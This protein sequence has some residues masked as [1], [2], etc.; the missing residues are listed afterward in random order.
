MPGEI[1]P[2]RR[3]PENDNEYF[4]ILTKAVFQA[5]FSY[6]VIH[7]KWDG[8]REVFED[9]DPEI[10]SRWGDAEIMDA[11]DSEKIVRNVKKIR[12][13]IENASKFLQI[14]KEY[15]SFGQYLDELRP[16]GYDTMKNSI[17]KQFKWLGKT[18]AY[19]LLYSTGEDVPAWDKR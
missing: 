15:G 12:A 8:F 6:K 3:K 5:G 13:T 2:P 4:E 7:N 18:G 1:I 17:T 9:F 16:N 14:V 10:L 11:L 19:F